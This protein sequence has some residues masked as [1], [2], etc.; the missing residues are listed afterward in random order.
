MEENNDLTLQ[1]L[2]LAV[3][4]IKKEVVASLAK[5]E[6]TLAAHTLSL[7]GMNKRLVR[8]E[9][10]LSSAHD[11]RQAMRDAIDALPCFSQV[12][13]VEDGQGKLAA[14]IRKTS[15]KV[16]DLKRRVGELEKA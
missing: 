13:G 2:F 1:G 12:K 3:G 8:I 16:A 6:G 15:N 11:E 9:E 14:E 7:A 4:G 10:Q 5:I